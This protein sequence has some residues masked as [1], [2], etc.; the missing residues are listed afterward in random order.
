MDQNS[1]DVVTPNVELTWPVGLVDLIVPVYKNLDLVKKCID[2]ICAN[3]HEIKSASPR[4]LVIN[5]S[6]DDFEV[7]TYL[8]HAAEILQIDLL[9]ENEVNQGFVKSVNK[10]LAESRKRKASAILINSDTETFPGTLKEIISVADLDDQFAFVCPRSNN[11]SLCTF[12]RPPHARAGRTLTSDD[13]FKVW[14]EIKDLLPK[15]TLAP[16]SIGFYLLIKSVI[17]QNFDLLDERFGVGYEEENDLV[18]R[19][20][21]VGFRAVLAN[22]AFAFHAG[23]ASFSLTDLALSDHRSANLDRLSELHPEFLPNVKDFESSPEHRA[24]LLLKGLLRDSKG[25]YDIAFVL[26][27]LGRHH[28]GTSEFVVNVLRRF[29]GV[30]GD[31][32]NIT[33]I[34]DPLTAEFHGLDEIGARRITP[35]IDQTYAIAFNFGQ[36]YDLHTVNVME[37]IAP[38]VLYSMLDVIS[39]DCAPLRHT[40]NIGEIWNY[41]A[42]TS[43][44]LVFIS[45]FSRATF[46]RRF[47]TAS[48]KSFA[49]LLSTQTDCYAARYKGV[50][51]GERHIYIAGNH[52]DHKDSTRTAKFLANAFPLL[53]FVVFG[54]SG[55]Y[56]SNAKLLH[57]GMVSDDDIV[58]AI[59][60]SS[61]IVLPSFYEGFGFTLM[62]ALA[63]GKPIVARDIPA[64]REILRQFEGASGIYL[65]SNDNELETLLKTALTVRESSVTR[66]L[67]D[68]WSEWTAHLAAFLDQLIEDRATIRPLAEKRMRMG[69]ALRTKSLVMNRNTSSGGLSSI[70]GAMEESF[71]VA[72]QDLADLPPGEFVDR[73]YEAVHGRRADPEG[74]LHHIKLLEEGLS[75]HDMLEALIASD[76]HRSK[77]RTVKVTGLPVRKDH[78]GS[79]KPLFA[80][81]I[82]RLLR[83]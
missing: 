13:T 21:K 43:N 27:S 17:L 77:N 56:P 42:E 47:P 66:Q 2:S 70:Q 18:S 11:A 33:L 3:K 54:G 6:P 65:Y 44:G 59:C 50:R 55:E 49:R 79:R 32:Y 63:A 73:L 23:S 15:Y 38:I 20:G 68:N 41:A 57:S 52:F 29:V 61:V 10:G 19:A 31:R 72:W 8:R 78:K 16:T 36:P 76:E 48:A 67:G 37:M 12:P 75:K 82:L 26:L 30:A 4:L 1:L 81:R 53:S 62:H 22:H 46:A 34:C 14:A 51:Q 28:D 5:D 24:E 64:T 9:I 58:T 60:D 71:V 74:R 40:Q 35:T 39:L 83:R 69:D 7:T 45:D 25:R 80:R